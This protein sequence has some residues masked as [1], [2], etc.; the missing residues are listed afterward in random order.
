MIATFL[1]RGHQGVGGVLILREL[2][3]R[4]P[5]AY[6]ELREIIRTALVAEDPSD[7]EFVPAGYTLDKSDPDV[8][9]LRRDD[10]TFVAAFS[11]T[12]ISVQG[13]LD[14]VKEDERRRA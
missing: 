4:H 13:L 12:G 2:A 7:Y 14:A 9:V 8:F 11:A 1:L 3:E 6:E 10:G 5:Q